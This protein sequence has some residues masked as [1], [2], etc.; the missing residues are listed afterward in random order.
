MQINE[1][2]EAEERSHSCPS[3]R[4][5][6]QLIDMRVYTSNK[7]QREKV[8]MKIIFSLPSLHLPKDINPKDT[9]PHN[10]IAYKITLLLSTS[11]SIAKPST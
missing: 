7:A 10:S 1:W 5:V 4:K 11:V 2:P 8:Q 6:H 3:Q 9:R